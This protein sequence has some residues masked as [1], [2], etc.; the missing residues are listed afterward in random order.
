MEITTDYINF[1][2]GTTDY[3]FKVNC[4][5]LESNSYEELRKKAMKKVREYM[6]ENNIIE[7]FVKLY[8]L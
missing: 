3:Q 8:Y 2:A 1:R 4:S 5:E 6:K 7:P